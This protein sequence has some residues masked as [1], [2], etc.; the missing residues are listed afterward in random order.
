MNGTHLNMSQGW[1]L[2]LS[3]HRVQPVWIYLPVA[4]LFTLQD[5]P[6][7]ELV[8][9]SVYLKS[10]VH[11]VSR[12]FKRQLPRG[13]ISVGLADIAWIDRSV[14]AHGAGFLS[15]CVQMIMARNGL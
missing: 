3:D 12:S 8:V 11:V 9:W 4:S 6:V 5:G 1:T 10:W 15:N 2:N 14:V 7:I 13:H